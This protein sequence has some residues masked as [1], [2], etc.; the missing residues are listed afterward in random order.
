MNK[1]LGIILAIACYVLWGSLGLFW[2][3][4]SGVNSYEV[5]SYRILATVL[6][7]L[8]YF[9]FTGRFSKLKNE[10]K[11]VRK[12]KKALA[13]GVIAAFL[14]GT[15]WLVYIIAIANGQATSASLGYYI[16]PLISVLLAVIFLKEKIERYTVIAVIV[17]FIGVLLM[18]LENGKLPV[19]TLVLAITFGLYGLFKKNIKMSSDVSITFEAIVIAPFVLI[20]LIFFAQ[21]SFLSYSVPE[22]V[23]L[24][25]SGIVTAIP[26]LL[27]AESLKNADLNTVGFLQYINPS[28]QL[29]VALFVF[30]E[31][32]TASSFQSL[33]LILLSILIFII[34]QIVSLRRK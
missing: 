2:N 9:L 20:F 28:L 32:L 30:K 24:L 4:L 5:F 31:S 11:E 3:L 15:N 21:H 10:L 16:T 17:A 27:F 33:A 6:T 13:S 12:S 19:I 18:T 22:M 8:L 7:M 26:L 23:F 14:V 34:G 1:K 29:L 25:L